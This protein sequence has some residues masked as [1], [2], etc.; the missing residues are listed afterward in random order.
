M[1]K[2][3]LDEHVSPAVAQ[4]LRRRIPT[5]VIHSMAE[6]E[7]GSFLGQEDA[8]CLQAAAAAGLTLVT[9]DWRTIPL[10]LKMWGEAGRNH[11]GVI[12]VDEKTISPADTGGL[13][14][15]LSQLHKE[16]GRWD[17]TDRVVFL[18]R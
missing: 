11:G 16:A 12:F 4:G 5:L 18:R 9:Y 17:W 15:A 2:L 6:W 13:V 10:P 8:A 14:R 7:D 1:L 3:L